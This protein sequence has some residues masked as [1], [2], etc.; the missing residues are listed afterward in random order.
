LKILAQI[1]G[2]YSFLNV[3]L[4]PLKNG[5]RYRRL[6]KFI[7][8]FEIDNH[9]IKN[10]LFFVWWIVEVVLILQPLSGLSLGALKWE[11]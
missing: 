7:S 2:W 10:I 9:P 8:K 6:A 3:F 11:D 1:L 5:I 4:H